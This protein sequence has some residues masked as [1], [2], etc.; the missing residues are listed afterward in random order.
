M[1]TVTCVDWRCLLEVRGEEL[2]RA[3]VRFLLQHLCRVSGC[4]LVAFH[5]LS[6]QNVPEADSRSGFHTLLTALKRKSLSA[7]LK[8]FFL[9]VVPLP[10]TECVRRTSGSSLIQR[11][12][13]RR[14]P[15]RCLLVTETTTLCVSCLHSRKHKRCKNDTQS[16]HA[17]PPAVTAPP[18][19]RQ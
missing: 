3:P 6:T 13:S 4:P 17:T 11:R 10:S 12:S 15:S 16:K 7:R 1:Q 8:M 9:L 19:A 2:L 5:V 18:A 14:S